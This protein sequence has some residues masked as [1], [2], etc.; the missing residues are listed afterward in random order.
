MGQAP[1]IT[2]TGERAVPGR[3]DLYAFSRIYSLVC[4]RFG[5]SQLDALDY[6]CGTGYGTH[7]LSGSFR[8]VVGI[9]VDR[10]AI[11]YCRATQTADNVRFELFDPTR[12]PFPD[13]TYDRVFS[14]QVFEHV[15]LDLTG[16][17]LRNIWNMLRPGGVAVITTP[18]SDNYHGGHSGN[19]FHVKEYTLAEMVAQLAEVVPRGQYRVHAVEDVLSTRVRIRIARA[20]RNT[21]PARAVARVAHAPLAWL[22]K[23][24]MI[25][26]SHRNMVHET[27]MARTVG[28]WYIEVHR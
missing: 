22:E 21:A 6:G 27:S 11:D 12:Q 14:F 15:P 1:S 8:S 3:G 24:G 20:G 5:G 28:S 2:Y 25:S 17:Y 26:T 16:V 23:V 9:D 19:P 4:D 13:E 18:K 7:L 10:E